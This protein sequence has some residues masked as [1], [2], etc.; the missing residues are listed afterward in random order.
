[1]KPSQRNQWIRSRLT[2]AFLVAAL[3]LALTLQANAKGRGGGGNV[4]GGVSGWNF[5]NLV[6]D[7]YYL[8]VAANGRNNLVSDGLGTYVYG[9][10]RVETYVG[11]NF[12][13]QLDPNKK[14]NMTSIRKFRFQYVDPL[15]TLVPE[16][17]PVTS[18]STLAASCVPTDS[19]GTIACTT[20]V[21]QPALEATFLEPNAMLQISGQDHDNTPVNC[22]R[23]VNAVITIHALNA[24]FLVRFGTRQHPGGGFQAPCGSCLT[25]KRLD[26]V[27]SANPGPSVWEVYTLPPHTGYVY[28][29]TGDNSPALFLGTTTLRL[30]GLLVS[31]TTEP[32]PTGSCS[33]FPDSGA[34]P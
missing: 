5:V 7:E 18:C 23:Q 27:S 12:S 30:S 21:V 4:G 11:R 19:E 17:P 9:S 20:P 1:M 6:L 13:I 32:L 3:V 33:A 10:Q 22:F 31:Q 15:W 29:V 26:N 25:V 34:C 16:F 24:T 14:D 28:L 8:N 2:A